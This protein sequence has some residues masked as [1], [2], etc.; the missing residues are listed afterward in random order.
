[1]GSNSSRFAP[2]VYTPFL[3]RFTDERALELAD[4]EALYRSVR[5][6]WLRSS[7][8][9]PEAIEQLSYQLAEKTVEAVQIPES[10]TLCAAL[11][12][13]QYDLIA[14][15]NAIFSCPEIDFGR[16]T[17]SLQER[18][19][20]RRFL[21]AQEYFLVNQDRV[22]ELFARTI[23]SLF[24]GLIEDLPTVQEGESAFTVPLLSLLRDPRDTVAKIMGTLYRNDLAEAGLFTTVQDQFYRNVCHASGVLPEA[25][26]RKPLV[27]ADQSEL[28]PQEL[29]ETYLKD[30]PFLDLL[31]TPIPFVIPEAVRF[32]H[33]HVLAGSGHGKTQTLQ[34]LILSNLTEPDPPSLVIIDSQGDMIGKLSH[35]ALFDPNDGPLADRLIIID[36]TDIDYPPALNLFDVNFERLRSY[37]AAAREQIL[38]G[39][40]ELYDYIFGSLLG[41][42]LT[43]KQSVIFRYLAR[44]MLA[45]PGATIHT[46]IELMGDITPFMQNIQALPPGAR[47]FFETEFPHKT[48][49]DTKRQIQ[50]RLWGILENPTFERMLTAPTNRVDMFE[51]LN[52]GKIVLVN[53]AKDFLKA[54][55]SSFLGRLFIAL[56]LQAALERAALPE[57]R[58]RP[59][60]LY[61]DEAADYFD[62]NIDDL[63]TQ[64]RKYKLGLLFSHQYLGQLSPGLHSSIASNT[65]IKLAG[66]ISDRDARGMAPDMRTAPSFIL[67]QRKSAKSTQFACSVRN[68]TPSALSLSIAF[69]ALEREPTMSEA[70]Y[71]ELVQANRERVSA[72][73]GSLENE[74]A[75]GVVTPDTEKG[76]IDGDNWS[77]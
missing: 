60:F 66:G 48:F 46:L 54:E 26:Q 27:S 24:C 63:L 73:T 55:R 10:R 38:N 53:T 37:G 51:A 62:N 8:A 33:T 25:E 18:V 28:P 20:L 32:E 35:L 50:R 42:E 31:R 77:S 40:I 44:L 34:Q 29:V 1:M 69:G 9:K 68:V 3:R 67:E 58:R 36:P 22:S 14:L 41:A 39:V 64:A 4:T 6:S 76:D 2:S 45:I 17:L 49:T 52:T 65:S 23:L 56:T 74:I 57:E 13:C 61:I 12:R 47:L 21:R 70:A 72:P 7:W 75:S 59:A 71:D 16:A 43:Q 15:E 19:D 11:D 5:A 30:T